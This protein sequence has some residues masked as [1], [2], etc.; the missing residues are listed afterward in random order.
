MKSRGKT[1]GEGLHGDIAQPSEQNLKER[2]ILNYDEASA[3]CR[4]PRY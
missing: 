1:K 2:L 3:N 4:N